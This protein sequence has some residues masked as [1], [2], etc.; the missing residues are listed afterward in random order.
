MAVA[1]PDPPAVSRLFS[2][3]TGRDCAASRAADHLDLRGA[4]VA[5]ELHTDAGEVLVV[6]LADRALANGAGAALAMFPAG[7][8]DEATSAGIVDPDLLE[9]FAEILNIASRLINEGGEVHVV[10]GTTGAPADASE[11]VREVAGSPGRRADFAV[12]VAGYGGG[13]LTLLAR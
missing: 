3:L 11:A 9:N 5:A 1:L 2:E 12:S 8:A 6:A 13:R 10:L 4:A 7:R